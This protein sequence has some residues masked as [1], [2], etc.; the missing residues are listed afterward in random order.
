MNCNSRFLKWHDQPITLR[1]PH[2]PEV[3]VITGRWH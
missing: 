1:I 2:V 3:G